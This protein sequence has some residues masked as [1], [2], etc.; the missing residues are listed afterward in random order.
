MTCPRRLLPAG[1]LL[2]SLLAAGCVESVRTYD[3][4]V[5]KQRLLGALIETD[6]GL[7]AIKLM[8][9]TDDVAAHKAEFDAFIKSI[10]IPGKDKERIAWTVPHG[11]EH[12]AG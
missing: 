4:P 7:W 2:F 1:L 8:R 12:E 3:V 6:D 11:W 9:K 5:T 10:R